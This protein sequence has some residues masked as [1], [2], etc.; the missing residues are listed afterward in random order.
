MFVGDLKRYKIGEVAELARVSRRTIDYY[1]KMGLLNSVRSESKYRYYDEE[2][3]IRLKLIEMM[4]E[5][6]LTL[7]E[8]R[9]CLALLSREGP[10][11]NAESQAKAVNLEMIRKQ[12]KQLERQLSRLQPAGDKLEPNQAAQQTRQVLLQGMTLLHTLILYINE[13]SPETTPFL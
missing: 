12:V 3:L 11:S 2:T 10:E 1:T 8:I 9:H 6:R 5:K 13:I 4:K 7:E